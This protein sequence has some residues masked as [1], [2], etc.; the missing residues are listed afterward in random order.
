MQ[1]I[2]TV[3]NL[4][5]TYGN[6]K[7]IHDISFELKPGTILGVIGLNGAG[8]ST[9]ISC[10]TGA[11]NKNSG[12]INYSFEAG[13]GKIDHRTLDKL[14]VVGSDYGFP[15][16]FTAK[17]VNSVMK[18]SYTQWDSEKFFD[19]LRTLDLDI[20]LKTKKYSTG[21]KTKLALA[22]ALS[23][24]ARVLILD[25]ATRGLDIKASSAIR[26]VLYKHIESGEN[27]VIMTSHIMG[28]IERMS[29][30]ILL[31]DEGRNTL[32]SE[33]D[34]LLYTHKVFQVTKEQFA[35]IDTTH[36][37]KYRKDDYNTKVIATDPRVFEETYHIQATES[38][39][40]TIIELLLEG[41]VA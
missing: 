40:D 17:T 25:E 23:H 38:S 34:S 22:I 9:L 12:E 20:T 7:G 21:M 15:R 39:L 4:T 16:H 8:K 31:I 10:L 26:K 33:K 27:A 28:E 19:I 13:R 2:L 1:P 5:K 11:L 24:N 35:A 18:H 32:Y 36:L 30:E 29:D 14:G 41:E 37:L 3:N 6:N